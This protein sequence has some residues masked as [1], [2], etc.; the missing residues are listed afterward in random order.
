MR[1]VLV[2]CFVL[3]S[4]C[5]PVPVQDVAPFLESAEALDF[6]PVTVGATRTRSVAVEG[7]GPFNAS[8]EAPFFVTEAT[9]TAPVRLE[10]S[11][12]PTEPG[13]F[14]GEVV[15]EGACA[16]QA[17][18]S[19]RSRVTRATRARLPDGTSI[20]RAAWW[21]CVKTVRRARKAA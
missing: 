18:A 21:R 4:S 5:R 2:I 6:G 17:A 8:T 19:L 20:R 3:W 15:L 13:D 11:F 12:A 1:T 14:S 16:F 10:V 7:R 9:L